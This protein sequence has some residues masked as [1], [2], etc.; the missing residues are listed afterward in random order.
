MAG[1]ACGGARGANR[2]EKLGGYV[3]Y[4]MMAGYAVAWGVSTGLVKMAND[5]RDLWVGGL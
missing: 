5:G 2:A 1:Y 4:V 3:G